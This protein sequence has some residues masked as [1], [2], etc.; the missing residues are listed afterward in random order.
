MPRTGPRGCM[1]MEECAVGTRVR[2][3]RTGTVGTVTALQAVD[4]ETFAVLDATGLLYRLDQLVR[5]GTV[6]ERREGQVEDLTTQLERE[7]EGLYRADGSQFELDNSC[8]GG[9]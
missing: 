3:T 9:G 8:E 1:Q 2:Y 6:R 5:A 7:R 4:G